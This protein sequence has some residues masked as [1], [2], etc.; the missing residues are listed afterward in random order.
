MQS[1]EHLTRVATKIGNG[2]HIFVPKEWVGEEIVLVKPSEKT[3]KERIMKIVE[4]H[5]EDIAGVYLYGSYA[6]NEQSK[7]SDI[8]ILII[9]DKKIKIK[10]RGKF[11]IINISKQN[12][13]KAININPILIYSIINESKPIINSSLLEELKKFKVIKSK[14]KE[15]FEGTKRIIK[16]NKEFI[17]MDKLDGEELTSVAV[18][19]SLILRLRGIFI[20]YCLIKKQ[21]YSNKSFKKWIL[22]NIPD[23]EYEKIYKIYQIIRENK[24]LS[25]KIKIIEAEKLLV[26]LEKEVKRYEK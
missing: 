4:P 2:A 1:Q 26:L 17:E 15:F 22:Q 7:N 11:D 18:I 25:A 12:I 20:I 3:L 24:E 21:K 10:K 14:F 16:I 19:Y 9:S 5:L 6:R 23:L 13:E 8:D